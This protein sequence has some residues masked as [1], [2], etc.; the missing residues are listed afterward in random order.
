MTLQNAPHATPP[1]AQV[2][3]TI[4]SFKVFLIDLSMLAGNESRSV[5]LLLS[6]PSLPSAFIEIPV[7]VWQQGFVCLEGWSLKGSGG[8]CV[9]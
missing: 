7:K 5:S 6:H 3:G 4:N 8:P 2:S 1:P 9:S